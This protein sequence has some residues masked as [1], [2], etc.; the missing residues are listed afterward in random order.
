[1][2]IYEYECR[3]CG[4]KLEVFSRPGEEPMKECM[5]CHGPIKKVFHPAGIIFKGSGFYTTDYARS[6]SKKEKA[7]K[8]EDVKEKAV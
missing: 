7:G 3:K 8:K 4:H 5:V 1:M 6:S 2:P